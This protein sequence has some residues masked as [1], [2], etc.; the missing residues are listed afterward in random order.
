MCPGMFGV[1][2]TNPASVPAV[3]RGRLER[4]RVGPRARL[5]RGFG[6]TPKVISRRC[7]GPVYRDDVGG[8]ESAPDEL[9]GPAH[10]RVT[11]LVPLELRHELPTPG[12][13]AFRRTWRACTSRTSAWFRLPGWPR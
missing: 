6:F 13:W 10:P 11:I 9:D 3:S 1:P 12:S 8:P 2:Q 7:V 5:V 4:D